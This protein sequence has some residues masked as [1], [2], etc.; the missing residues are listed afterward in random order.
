MSVGLCQDQKTAL[1]S[2]VVTSDT[3]H[4]H[5]RN[6]VCLK[7]LIIQLI[8]QH[9]LWNDSQLRTATVATSAGTL[10]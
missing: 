7:D 5:D 6:T 1:R 3:A 9:K 2:L 8:K 10:L 4:C